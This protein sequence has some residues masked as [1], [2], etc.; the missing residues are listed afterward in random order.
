MNICSDTSFDQFCHQVLAGLILSQTLFYSPSLWRLWLVFMFL[1]H[2]IFIFLTSSAIN[3]LSGHSRTE[4]ES[5]FCL[6]FY[7]CSMLAGRR[8]NPGIEKLSKH[9]DSSSC[10]LPKSVID[11]KNS[12]ISGFDRH[13]AM[14]IS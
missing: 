2:F 13:S 11:K 9:R 7:S 10:S 8:E 3:Q 6:L 12:V 4:S 5:D 14:K 1:F